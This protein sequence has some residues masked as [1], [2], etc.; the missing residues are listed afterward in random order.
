VSCHRLGFLQLSTLRANSPLTRAT[1]DKPG[2]T[3][4]YEDRLRVGVGGGVV[5]RHVNRGVRVRERDAREVPVLTFDPFPPQPR[6]ELREGACRIGNAGTCYDK[7]ITAHALGQSDGDKEED[8]DR[9]R[10]GVGGGVV[11][12]H[13]NRGASQLP[14]DSRHRGQTRMD[15]CMAQKSHFKAVKTGTYKEEDE[16]RLRVGVGGGVVRR[17]V[18]R[19]VRVRERDAREVHCGDVVSTANL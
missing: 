5:R 11:R 9:L 18:N 6:H 15:I 2:W 19:G 13:V 10:V 16:D 4:A 7:L 14:P 17:H 12:R 3:F 8:E 1:V